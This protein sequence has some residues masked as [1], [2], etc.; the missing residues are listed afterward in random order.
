MLQQDEPDDYVV[1]SGSTH[2]IKEFLTLAFKAVGIDDWK[3][4]VKQDQRFMRPAEVDVL[5]GSSTKAKMKLGWTPKT[6]FEDLVKIM[7]TSDINKLKE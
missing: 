1:A 2:S 4:Y 7:I 6:N 5:L 3:D